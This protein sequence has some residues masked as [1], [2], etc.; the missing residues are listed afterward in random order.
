MYLNPKTF[1]CNQCGECCEIVVI[2]TKKE[3]KAIKNLGYKEDYFLIIDPIKGIKKNCLKRTNGNC[4]FLIKK[5]DKHYCKIYKI[6]PKTCRL[7]PFLNKNIK[8]SSCKPRDV[9]PFY[10]NI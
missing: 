4:V 2:L 7:Y 9:F 3:I 8:I 5:G 1:T 6:R 10:K